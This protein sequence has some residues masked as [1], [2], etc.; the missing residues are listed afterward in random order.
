MSFLA[1]VQKTGMTVPAASALGRAV[2]QL[3]GADRAFEQVLLHEGVV[4][5]DDGIDQLRA[6]GGQIDGAAGRRRFRRIEDADDA[7][8][9][10]AGVD[11]RVEQ[12]AALAEGVAEGLEQVGELDVV[13]VELVDDQHAGQAALAGLVEHAARV[14]LDAVGRRH[15]H[16]HVL[17]GGQRP[18]GGADESGI[19]GRVEQ[20]DV[21]ALVLQVQDAGVD[22]EVALVFFL[23]VVG[24]AGAVVHAAAAI[25][26]LGLEQQGVGK[27]GLARRPMSRQGD[28]PNVR[29]LI[30]PHENLLFGCG[31]A[32]GGL[33][34]SRQR[35]D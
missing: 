15:D 14:D 9:L 26:G 18:Q 24:D 17:D 22:G 21:L 35:P 10:R 5:L 34:R 13:G 12:H 29:H 4:G 27:R 28:V 30:F 2:G 25:D 8:E 16:Y 23:V 31:W 7:A 20:V 33:A 3:L 1:A 11:R 32:A 6:G 19:A